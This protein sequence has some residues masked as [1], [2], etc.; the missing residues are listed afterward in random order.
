MTKRG[1]GFFPPISDIGPPFPH[2]EE[3]YRPPPAAQFTNGHAAPR[4][5]PSAPE[6]PWRAID[7]TRLEG[8]PV[9]ERRWIVPEWLPVRVVTLNY[10]DGGIGKTLLALQLM[11]A[12][13]IPNKR[14]CGLKVEPC[15]SVGLFTEDDL[16]ELHFRIDAIRRHYGVQWADLGDMIPIEGTGQDNFLVEFPGDAMVLT[17]RWHQLREQIHDVGA[18]LVVLDTA[19]TL[20]GGNEIDRKQVTQ[21]V[22]LLTKL[23]QEIDGAV[24]LNC[25]PSLSSISSGDLRSGSTA[26]NNSCRSRWGLTRPEGDDGKLDLES[27]IRLLTKR[28]ANQSSTGETLSLEWQENVFVSSTASNLANSRKDDAELAFLGALNDRIDKKMHTSASPRASNYGPRIFKSSIFARDFN[29]KELTDAMN[30]LLSRGVI[31][32]ANYT[33]DYRTLEEIRPVSKR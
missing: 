2:G 8:K 12:A 31:E 17:R 1:G 9:P 29:T 32:R 5:R 14:W 20:F 16:D 13:A 4:P 23:A 18:R 15:C 33:S 22:T 11:M 3:E 30:N 19:A 6:Q 28:K 26:W 7:L 27:P 21:F 25:H 24:L 10:A